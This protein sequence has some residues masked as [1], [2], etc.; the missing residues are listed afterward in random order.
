MSKEPAACVFCKIARR[1][2][3]AH[4]IYEDEL[5]FAFLDRAPI[6]PGHTLIT[7]KVHYDYFD[8]LPLGLATRLL[9]IGQRLA[10]AMK[11]LY[12]VP[13]VA[14][15]FTG[16]DI[17]HAHAHIVPMVEATDITSRRYIAE[18]K[19]TFGPL[20]PVPKEELEKQARLLVAALTTVDR[21]QRTA[22][23]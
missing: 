23:F 21:T 8:D 15:A 6:R 9:D 18:D 12:G 1:E 7:P 3:S 16:T 10:K 20:P 11:D 2:F 5:V 17:P 13:R 19:L 22:Q 4:A 14:M